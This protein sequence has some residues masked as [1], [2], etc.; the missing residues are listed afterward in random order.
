MIRANRII[1]LSIMRSRERGHGPGNGKN[2]KGCV[3]AA[4]LGDDFGVGVTR[5]VA[6]LSGGVLPVAMMVM[7]VAWV[8]GAGVG[9]RETAL[10]TTIISPTIHCGEEVVSYS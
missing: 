9:S 1:M 4:C 3:E 5:V 2:G 10:G 6:R 8:S 7:A